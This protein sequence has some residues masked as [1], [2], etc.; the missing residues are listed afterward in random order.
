MSNVIV[1]ANT[2]A[3]AQSAWAFFQNAGLAPAQPSRREQL[4]PQQV[5]TL[6]VKTTRQQRSANSAALDKIWTELATDLTLGN[7]E[8][9][10]CGWW[11]T[12]DPHTPSFWHRFDPDTRF[13]LVY[14]DPTTQ[15]AQA[16]TETL[17]G[18]RLAANSFDSDMAGILQAWH[19]QHSQLLDTF[20]ALSADAHLV[21]TSQLAHAAQWL[22]LSPESSPKHGTRTSSATKPDTGLLYHLLQPLVAAYPAVQNLWPQLQAAAQGPSADPEPEQEAAR[23]ALG[24]W[25]QLQQHSQAMH[26][27]IGQQSVA[28]QNLLAQLNVEGKT[29]QLEANGK[30]KAEQELKILKHAYDQLQRQ[31]HEALAEGEF[32]LTQLHQVQE[33]LESHFF[34]H[35]EE[36]KIKLDL[37]DQLMTETLAREVEAQAQVQALQQLQAQHQYRFHEA[38]EEGELLLVQLHQVQEELEEYFLKYQQQRQQYEPVIDF[39]HQ[40]PPAEI[41]VDM[42]QTLDG[43]GWYGAEAD[44]RWS[45]PVTESTV[46]LPPLAAGQYLVE[47]HLA[48]AMVPEQ[49]A[50]MQLTALVDEGGHTP[51]EFPV[52]LVHEFGP[53]QSL[54]PM[55]SAGVLNLSTTQTV[56]QLRLVLPEVISPA[57]HGGSDTRQ[58]GVRLQGL[59]LS[60]QSYPCAAD[61]G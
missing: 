57:T 24:Q 54:Y 3:I 41:W 34:K 15:T 14:E 4:T 32:L 61:Q 40:H 59:R 9:E 60:M 51:A 10:R 8:T 11:Q 37:Q 31:L 12:I 56:W 6:M 50:G 29:R 36:I 49:V 42:S 17:Q 53:A 26:V 55:V 27:Q 18:I 39:W 13:V 7:L 30:D 16:L 1:I 46:A 5:Q 38:Q 47:L 44:G 43:Q 52:E 45:G 48:D 2:Q 35:Q 58:L 33:E 28:H 19:D 23:R 20:F 22:E 21:H 25:L